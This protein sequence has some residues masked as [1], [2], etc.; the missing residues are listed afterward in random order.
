ME[1]ISHEA[2]SFA[3]TLGLSKL[4]CIYDDNGISI[5]GETKGW[6]TE[7]VGARF[8]AYGW[9]VIRHVD[10]HDP[11]SVAA[12]LAEAQRQDKPDVDPLPHRDRFRLAEQ[13]RHGR[14][15]RRGARC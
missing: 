4:T 5:D 15:A 11:A 6:F 10:G 13:A 12:A 1:G 7:D 2:G 9:H 8:E 14:S 3:G